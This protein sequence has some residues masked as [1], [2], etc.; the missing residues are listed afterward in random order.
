MVLC[1]SRA[2]RRCTSAGMAF[3]ATMASL[4]ELGFRA[5]GSG[6]QVVESRAQGLEKKGLG[7]RGSSAGCRVQGVRFRIVNLGFRIQGRG[8]KVQDLGLRVQELGAEGMGQ[9]LWV[10]G[11]KDRVRVQDLGFF[12]CKGLNKT[13]G[14]EIEV[15]F[16]G[17]RCAS[18]IGQRGRRRH[19]CLNLGL[20]VWGLR[21]RVQGL[22]L[23][24]QGF[25]GFMGFEGLGF[26][27]WGFKLKI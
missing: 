1:R 11:Q 2:P 17:E 26:K 5:Q 18:Q 20:R 12:R 14:L 8:F 9:G 16:V 25:Q 23:R 22:G 6:L 7:V 10:R 21:S 13:K 24:A 27:V 19:R 15:Y 3:A 4:Q